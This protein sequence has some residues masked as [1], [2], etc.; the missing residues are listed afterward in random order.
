MIC[1]GA[2][3]VVLGKTSELGPI[4][5]QILLRT[6][7]EE[8]SFVSAWSIIESY[9]EL[10]DQA[11]RCGEGRIEPYLQQL[12]RYDARLIKEW[13]R[14]RDLTGDIAAHLLRT[15]MMPDASPE[16]IKDKVRLLLDPKQTKSHG[17]PIYWE[18][19]QEMGLCVELVDNQ[20]KL[21]Q[22]VFE[23]HIRSDWYVSNPASKLIETCKLHFETAPPQR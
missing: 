11:V 18:Q 17:R 1:L 23:L 12:D 21:W 7:G 16:E 19:L 2:E 22:L 5:P 9:R 4:D 14:D 8:W 3:R 15:G 20:S 6:E 10:L 13:E